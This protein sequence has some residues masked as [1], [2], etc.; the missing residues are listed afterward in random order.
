MYRIGV[1][2]QGE[3]E[4]CKHCIPSSFVGMFAMRTQQVIQHILDL[5]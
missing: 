5:L 1:S 3:M 2:C 4:A